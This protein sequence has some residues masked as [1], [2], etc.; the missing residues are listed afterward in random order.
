V[1][2]ITSARNAQLCFCSTKENEENAWI[3]CAGYLQKQET[4]SIGPYTVFS[5]IA[6]KNITLIIL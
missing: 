2:C 6:F 5:Q 3:S 1:I 4:G